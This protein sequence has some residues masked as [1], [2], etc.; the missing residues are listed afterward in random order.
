MH[1]VMLSGQ[2]GSVLSSYVIT[3]CNKNAIPP[4][5]MLGLLGLSCAAYFF[6]LQETHNQAVSPDVQE[7]IPLRNPNEIITNENNHINIIKS[8]N[9]IAVERI[10]FNAAKIISNSIEESLNN[11]S[12]K[13]ENDHILKLES[14]VKSSYS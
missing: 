5:L 12:N 3:F 14:V 10:N 7:L 2:F 9:L 4:M 1:N 6:I 13:K 8:E 11:S